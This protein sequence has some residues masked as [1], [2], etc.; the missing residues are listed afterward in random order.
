MLLL[1]LPGVA[2]ASTEATSDADNTH[3]KG[4]ES[5]ATHAAC[6]ATLTAASTPSER[7]IL[8]QTAAKTH[9]QQGA[10]ADASF[11]FERAL[12][13]WRAIP[14]AELSVADCLVELADLARLQRQLDRAQTLLDEALTLQRTLAPGSLELA[15]SLSLQGTLA[16]YRGS[17]TDAGKYFQQAL[18]VQQQLAPDGLEVATS[19]NRLGAVAWQQG[20]LEEAQA[21]Y[22][23]SLAIRQ[24]RVPES[25]EVA[26]TLNNLALV[27]RSRGDLDT[28]EEL[29]Q[30]AAAIQA[31]HAPESLAQAN[32]ITNLGIIAVA[33]G[34]LEEGATYYHQAL[35]IRERIAPGSL[36]VSA[37]LN[38]LGIVAME[39]GDLAVAADYY[40]RALAI[41]R[42]VA[43][44][45]LDV[46]NS[47]TA[48]G[49]VAR[50]RGE[51]PQA[52][53]D[54]LEA[55]EILEAVAPDSVETRV[56]LSSLGLA[57][58]QQG[59]LEQAWNYSVRALSLQEQVAPDNIASA[60]YLNNIAL[61]ALD[62]GDLVAASSHAA[63]ALETYQR[64]APDS[65][66]MAATLLNLGQIAVQR[67][68]LDAAWQYHHQALEIRARLAPDSLELADSLNLVA[69]LHRK[70][71]LKQ[72]AA[73]HFERSITALEHQ[74]GKLGVTHHR[75]GSFR[76]QHERFY[77]DFI[78]HLLDSRSF[79]LAFDVLERFRA[80]SFLAM[81]AERDLGF[82][83]DVPES[84]QRTRRRI[85]VRYDRVQDQLMDLSPSREPDKIEALLAQLGR[86][87]QER[88][89]VA[90]AIR[91]T[92]PH[93]RL[94]TPPTMTVAEAREALDPGTVMLS[95]CVGEER[96]ELFVLH[97]AGDLETYELPV[98]R[99]DLLRDVELLR[100]LIQTEARPQSKDA[101]ASLE[102]LSS[103]LYQTLIAPAATQIADGSRLLIVP[104]G[105]LHLLPF[106]A[107]RHPAG[108]FLLAG[109]P[110][111][112]TVSMS[113]YAQQLE[114]RTRAEADDA[115]QLVAFGDPLF[116][117]HPK[118]P[119]T[120][121]DPS[122]IDLA[123]ARGF[124]L[125]PLIAS[126]HEVESIAEL[127]A[128]DSQQVYLGAGATE[129]R[130]KSVGRAV[131]HLHFATHAVLDPRSPLDSG[132]A[133]TRSEADANRGETEHTDNGFLQAWEIFEGLRLDADLVVLSAC[134]TGLGAIEGG[135]G[136]IG[137][138]RAFHYA[139]ARSVLSTLWRVD[140][141]ATADLMVRFYR[142][143]RAGRPKADALRAAQ[144]DLLQDQDSEHRE[145]A[146]PRDFS[147]PYFWAAFQLHG[148][149]R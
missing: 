46:A 44:G 59:D 119:D 55:L 138:T 5:T 80:R 83:A 92:S 131:N 135:E 111:H 134:E 11:D 130:A 82:D 38:N 91:Q 137:L 144:L 33:R 47:L 90:L 79:E 53:T 110:L 39:R 100:R 70:R 14:G 113:V 40:R 45:S 72:D 85:A 7:A 43:P 148:D 103:R 149:W 98:G 2:P 20:E 73:I 124:D 62:R 74:V 29:T 56:T 101:A 95:Y 13:I 86:L 136:L 6:D 125:K 36:D 12:D 75:Q 63:R 106:G 128:V 3:T 68:D 107:L 69:H 77:R 28:A 57:A 65:L 71:G 139:G 18:D 9:A 64:L 108:H 32:T 129:A 145:T 140:D 78:T 41:R 15:K 105:P 123:V 22:E 52:L 102:R 127:F 96:S 126:R 27:T 61:I 8:L 132:L 87:R 49:V 50:R 93:G 76:T 109:I 31:T 121:P 48:L 4:Q 58:W 147:A 88:D 142:H 89:D 141:E 16:W 21:L 146:S 10:L 60:T 116:A 34:D 120:A 122:S 25:L 23:R 19:F 114:T 54:A 51:T 42:E 143:L 118:A 97:S 17:L 66:K 84:L 104:D 115:L 35:E 99:E 112:S 117:K 94:Q 30:R 24:A 26:A 1:A 67:G 81:L 133:L 37:S